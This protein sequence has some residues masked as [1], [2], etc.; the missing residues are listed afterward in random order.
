MLELKPARHHQLLCK[1]LE[2]VADG[3]I[4]RL[5][6]FMPPGHAKSTYASL[7]FIAWFLGR[8]KK[9]E[10]G[11]STAVIHASHTQDLSAT[12]GRRIRNMHYAPEWPFD[13]KILEDSKAAHQWSTTNACEYLAAGVGTAIQGRRA[14]L[15]VIDDPIASYEDSQS[16]LVRKKLWEWYTTDLH[17]RLKPDAR[18]I[19][20]QTRWHEEDLAGRILPEGWGNQ[21][22]IVEGRDGHTWEVISLPAIAEE[23][24]ALGRAPGEALWPNWFPLDRL[25][26]EK[27]QS[28]VKWSALY[29][30]RPSP[31]EGGY[32]QREWLEFYQV[33]PPTE[34]LRIY[35]AS[36][37]AVTKDGDYTVHGVA[38]VDKDNNLYILD[39]W[40]EKADTSKW[41]DAWAHLV[42]RWRPIE[43]AEEMGQIQKSVGPFI[44]KRCE[45]LGIYT[46]RQQYSTAKD[47]QTKA[48]AIRGRLSQ[49]KVFLPSEA[50]WVHDLISEMMVF[51]NAAYDDQ[52][53][54]LSLFGRMLDKMA[55]P[56]A[57][58]AHAEHVDSGYR[59]LGW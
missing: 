21:S 14:D 51:P 31:A 17:T 12:W 37:Y 33:Q 32:F 58:L 39:W 59:R 53:D 40:R 50:P 56:R 34:S 3:K 30:Q 47:K 36:D 26:I 20:I 42:G 45:E 49:G 22:G 10:Y 8:L 54:V 2:D 48:Q 44:M 55:P 18:I 7:L 9:P 24:D 43:W 19:L 38:G 28:D 46:F 15:A 16:E 35:G 11:H 4:R 23:N 13:S 25:E 52:V 5:M 41:I 1:K 57:P 27:R 29:Q 6:I